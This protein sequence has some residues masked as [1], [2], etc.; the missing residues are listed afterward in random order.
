M[1]V[2]G[3]YPLL[4]L[5]SRIDECSISSEPCYRRRSW[6]SLPCFS[7][8][9][10]RSAFDIS[11][12]SPTLMIQMAR[13]HEHAIDTFLQTNAD[14]LAH[15][16]SVSDQILKLYSAS[17]INN[18]QKEEL[19]AKELAGWG[20]RRLAALLLSFLDKKSPEQKRT[21]LELV[22]EDQK[23]LVEEVLEELAR[24]DGQGAAAGRGRTHPPP[25]R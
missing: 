4:L 15:K 25:N 7:A 22:G 11:T 9:H 21:F 14:R 18:G 5:S 19:Q 20:E 12:R 6:R 13:Q 16:L 17:V 24:L 1:R 3:R 8:F 23:F 10:A 2:C